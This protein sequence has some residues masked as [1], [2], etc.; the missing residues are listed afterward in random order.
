MAAKKLSKKQ[1]V[2]S[3][4]R[5]AQMTK[6][7]RPPNEVLSIDKAWLDQRLKQHGFKTFA[8]LAR[9]ISLDKAAMVRSLKG[10]RAFTAKDIASLAEVLQATTDEILRRVGYKIPTRGVPIVGKVTQDARVSSVLPQ[11]GQLFQ[12]QDAPPDARALIVEAESGPLAFLNGARIVYQPSTAKQMPLSLLGE[13][14]IVEC[15][16]HMTP[17]VGCLQKGAS[18]NTSS[19][20]LFGTSEK[21]AVSVVHSA[22][23]VLTIYFPT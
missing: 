11:K 22:S 23:P 18:R 9:Y 14:C 6:R 3:K 4:G 13:L 1:A 20:Q 12:A 15:D 7:G 5:W 19:L 17:F 21:F 8:H 2:Q 10:E 16:N